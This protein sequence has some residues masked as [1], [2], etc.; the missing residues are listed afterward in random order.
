MSEKASK[1]TM[2]A[3]TTTATIPVLPKY[4]SNTHLPGDQVGAGTSTTSNFHDFERLA[5]LLSVLHGGGLGDESGVSGLAVPLGV[6]H[7]VGGRRDTPRVESELVVDAMG[8]DKVGRV[9]VHGVEDGVDTGLG[10]VVV[11]DVSVL[12][13]LEVTSSGAGSLGTDNIIGILGRAL[14]ELTLL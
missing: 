5:E 3:M 1:E 6:L 9:L 12:L 14:L 4:C 7:G 8:A 13:E 10:I 2:A 11:L